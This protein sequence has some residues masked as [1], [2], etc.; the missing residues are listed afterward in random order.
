MQEVAQYRRRLH[1]HRLVVAGPGVEDLI[2]R[3]HLVGGDQLL[4]D[5][6]DFGITLKC[7]LITWQRPWRLGAR[8]DGAAVVRFGYGNGGVGQGRGGNTGGPWRQEWHA[9][10]RI[11]SYAACWRPGLRR[12]Q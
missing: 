4:D 11:G 1:G 2:G 6:V 3:H 10:I 8:S 9:W 5:L 12:C 7:C